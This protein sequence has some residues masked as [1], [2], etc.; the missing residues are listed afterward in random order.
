M[1]KGKY[2]V[3][4]W[5]AYN[6]GLKQRGAITIWID[7]GLLEQWRYQGAKKKGGQF[8][9]SDQAIEV[10]LVVRQV[11]HL[12]FRQTEGFMESFFFQLQLDLPVPDYST[13]C[14]RSEHLP[15]SIQG[16]KG[17]AITDLVLDSTGLKV[18]GEGEWKVRMHGWGKHRAWMKLHIALDA[19]SQQVEAVELT[20]NAVDD[21]AV[22]DKLLQPIKAEIRS[23][24]G[25][26]AYDKDKVRKVLH[27]Q[28]ILPII[29]PQHNAVVDQKGRAYRRARND[30]IAFIQSQGREEWK[31]VSNYH[32][33]SKG[34]TFMYRYKVILGGSLRAREERRQETE[35]KIGCKILN[36]MLQTAK[37][38]SE[39]VA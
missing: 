18:Y 17:K 19:E 7:K 35:V 39:R 1:S 16:K 21:A 33:R 11:Y 25:D 38:Q 6:Q 10:C 9:Y 2:K 30:D 29:A 13:L 5:S 14:R 4:N 24:T 3:C 23:V 28:N 15:V 37:P 34:E 36:L 27:Q 31:I 20:T 32:Q 22:V 12:P 26:G 8:T